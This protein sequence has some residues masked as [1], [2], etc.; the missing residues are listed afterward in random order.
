[1]SAALQCQFFFQYLG[2]WWWPNPAGMA[3]DIRPDFAALAG[4]P[5]V[6]VGPIAF[7]VLVGL[8]AF[9]VISK[10]TKSPVGLASYGLWW[11][12]ALFLV[13]LS[14]VRF[15]EPVV[16]YRSYLWGPGFLLAAAGLVNL[17][18]ARWAVVLGL[19]AVL[20]L[21][22]IAWGRL[23]TFSNELALWEEAAAK[24]PQPTASG[25]IRIHY[26]R[27]IY[28]QRAGRIQGALEDFDWVIQQD[29]SQFYG[30]WARSLVYLS[31]ENWL[32]AIADLEAVIRLNP[33]FGDAYF[34]LAL[35]LKRM[36]KLGESEALL[37]QA[38]ARGMPIF[39]VN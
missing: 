13:E 37:A 32:D 18:P 4:F 34:Q 35:I 3:I 33:D 15:Q 22:P 26:N 12:A 36:G 17:L 10:K 8:A 5:V 20:T 25:A 2:L 14:T 27:G 11:A 38:E 6:L 31:Q 30:Y 7:A 1:M 21:G 9:G 23:A 24:L 29:P 39:R 28:R 19:I 16:L